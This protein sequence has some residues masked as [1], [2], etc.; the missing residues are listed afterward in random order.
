MAKK[1]TELEKSEVRKKLFEAEDIAKNSGKPAGI[2]IDGWCRE[3]LAKIHS[4]PSEA[5][6]EQYRKLYKSKNENP[7]NRER[8]NQSI[9]LDCKTKASFDKTRSAFRFC[10]AE[11]ITELRK[12]ADRA[13]RQ[14]N[15]E[16]MKKFTYEAYIKAYFFDKE[17]LSED[18]IIFEDVK[19]LPGYK[20]TSKSK[21][22][23]LSKAPNS[24]QILEIIEGDEKLYNRHALAF[25]VIS[26]FGIRPAELKKGVTLTYEDNKII[27]LVEGAK[28]GKDKGQEFRRLAVEID[29]NNRAEQILFDHIKENSGALQVFQEKKDYNHIRKFLN[30]I[31]GKPSLYTYRHKVASDLKKSGYKKDEIAKFLGH[32]TTKSQKYY[33]FA[34]SGNLKGLEADCTN[35]IKENH[36]IPPVKKEPKL[37]EKNK[38]KMLEVAIGKK[39][40]IQ[41]KKPKLNLKK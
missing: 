22:R 14:K 16:E 2:V 31:P 28:V 34:R 3:I 35:E 6:Q 24:D 39:S 4:A 25:S 15:F 13:R 36:T 32:R 26:T 30:G 10:I 17:F 11:E 9:L 21:K 40:N 18:R 33:G 37:Q 27:A 38:F 41:S 20:K 5:S 8:S 19:S 29:I 7:A 12:Q 23:N 1:Y